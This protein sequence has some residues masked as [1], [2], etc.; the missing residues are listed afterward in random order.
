MSDNAAHAEPERIRRKLADAFRN[1]AENKH[2][3]KK[4]RAAFAFMAATWEKTLK[5]EIFKIMSHL[6]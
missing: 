5:K 6:P 1:E 3:T 4:E 2:W